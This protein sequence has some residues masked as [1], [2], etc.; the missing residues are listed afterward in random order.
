MLKKKEYGVKNPN[1]NAAIKTKKKL[2]SQ[3]N[4]LLA[5]F[6]YFSNEDLMMLLLL[7]FS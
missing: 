4:I 3:G 1:A 6:G 2:K 5:V 7:F